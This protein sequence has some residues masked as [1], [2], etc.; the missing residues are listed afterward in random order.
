MF[1][2]T[3]FLT[4]SPLMRFHKATRLWP[5]DAPY[6]RIVR[7]LKGLPAS[8]GRAGSLELV[9]ATRKKDIRKA[10]K[11]RYKVFYE[12]GHAIADSRAR[13]TRRDICPY[14]RICDHL[15][16]IDHDHR[17]R[18]G[19][20]KPKVV[21]TYRLLRQDVADAHFG[22]YSQ[23][24]FDI[25]SLLERHRGKKFLELGRSCVHPAY[26]SKRTL[27]LL[28][29]G[30]WTYIN[31]HGIDV[32]IGCASF[33]GT[34]PLAHAIALSFLH[35]HVPA[36]DEWAAQAHK[37]RY[38]PMDIISKEAIDARKALTHLPPLIK[39]YLRCGAMF[40]DGAVID[41]MFGTTD[42]LVIMPVRDL[43]ERYMNHFSG[44]SS[45]PHAA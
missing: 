8:L 13:L 37:N 11:L 38:Y 22:F 17:S 32:M 12:D 10:Q 29:R 24:E 33:E 45:Q 28:W 42:V 9:L 34:Q 15:L 36:R 14:D 20:I 4:S 25:A 7:D 1:S 27:E 3:P 21:G 40:G 39:G 30:I 2:P 26:R 18:F 19:R 43:D 35:H 23:H 5:L 41:H 6:S 16:V 31:H 44:A